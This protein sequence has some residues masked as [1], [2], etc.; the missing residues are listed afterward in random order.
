MSLFDKR[1]KCRQTN[2]SALMK[3]SLSHDGFETVLRR[4]VRTSGNPHLFVVMICLR[5]EFGVIAME[6]HA[7]D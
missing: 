1:L 6:V 7:T 3:K 5:I 4:D 2:I